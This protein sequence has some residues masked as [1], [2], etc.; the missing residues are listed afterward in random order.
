[1]FRYQPDYA[2]F[3]EPLIYG[4]FRSGLLART[5]FALFVVALVVAGTL[6]MVY[7][8]RVKEVRTLALRET[9]R[10]VEIFAQSLRDQWQNVLNMAELIQDESEQHLISGHEGRLELASDLRDF[11][12]HDVAYRSFTILNPHLREW[13][14]VEWQGEKPVSL[15]E[16]GDNYL[17]HPGIGDK[18]PGLRVDAQQGLLYLFRPLRG[19]DQGIAGYLLIELSM[20]RLIDSAVPPSLLRL[21]A[22]WLFD[23]ALE[24][25]YRAGQPASWATGMR[26]GFLFGD[27]LWARMQREGKGVARLDDGGV[28]AYA[29]ASLP[30]ADGAEGL[31]LFYIAYRD[32]GSMLYAV[33]RELKDYLW[34]ILVLVALLVGG[35]LLLAWRWEHDLRTRF[36]LT[37]EGAR[38]RH[39]AEATGLVPYQLELSEEG[40]RPVYYDVGLQRMLG[41]NPEDYLD[42][43]DRGQLEWWLHRIHPDDQD[44]VRAR[45]AELAQASEAEAYSLRYRV[46]HRDQ[47]RYRWLQDEGQ[48]VVR[49]G[50]V[51][52][53]LGWWRDVDREQH[54]QL[55]QRERERQRRRQ[56][57]AVVACAQLLGRASFQQLL[58]EVCRALARELD[59]ARSG[60][61]MLS[62]DHARLTSLCL[63]HKGGMQ[64]QQT[65]LHAEQ[66]PSYFQAMRNARFID[67][68][69]APH[70]PRT[71]EFADDYLQPLGIS[72]M[73]DAAVRVHGRLWGVI[74]C[75]HLGPMRHWQEHERHFAA[76]MADIVAMAVHERERAQTLAVLKEKHDN[77]DR[78]IHQT[79][80]AIVIVQDGR[81]QLANTLA[82]RLL[83]LR[84]GV[85]PGQGLRQVA[86]AEREHAQRWLAHL[87]L[88]AP[89]AHG[90][91]CERRHF[92]GEDGKF[93]YIEGCRAPMQLH[94]RPA[95]LGIFRDLS[96]QFHDHAMVKLRQDLLQLAIESHELVTF[97][98]R[99]LNMLRQSPLLDDVT[100]MALYMRND[101]DQERATLLACTGDTDEPWP[102]VAHAHQCLCGR[103]MPDAGVHHCHAPHVDEG[104]GLMAVPVGELGILYM[105][106]P[107]YN[108][109]E[110]EDI[111][112]LL[113]A[114]LRQFDLRRH[115]QHLLGMARQTER[116]AHVGGWVLDKESGQFCASPEF[117]RI[118]DLPHE[119]H[120]VSE[121]GLWTGLPRHLRRHV[122]HALSHLVRHD[123]EI[124]LDFPYKA[125]DGARRHL[126]L[127]GR[128]GNA[129]H[130]VGALLDLTEM[131]AL[132]QQLTHQQLHDELTGLGN[133]AKA[134]E[135]LAIRLGQAD[136]KREK[137]AVITI[138]LADF[139]E[140]NHLL[141]H[142]GG[143]DV[144]RKISERLRARLR[145]RDELTRLEGDQFGII[146]LISRDDELPVL[147]DRVREAIGAPIGVDE[148]HVAVD[149]Y[150]GIAVYPDNGD[151]VQDLWDASEAAL[152]VAKTQGPG[153]V[154]Y[155]DVDMQQKFRRRQVLLAALRE[156]VE[157]G[158]F[159]VYLQPIVDARSGLPE[160]A[161]ALIR[162][163]DK[164]L[165]MVSPAEFI[166]LAEERG[167]IVEIGLF[168]LRRVCWE[169][170]RLRKLGRPLSFVALNIAPQ[171]LQRIGFAD[172]VLATLHEHHVPPEAL[173]IEIT[174]RTLLLDEALVQ[175]QLRQLTDA[176]V[177]LALDDFGTGYASLSY[178]G[179]FPFNKLKIDI[180]FIR[181]VT[182]DAQTAAL[183]DNILA[184][185]KSMGLDIVAEGVETRAQYEHLRQRGCAYIQG[186]YF[187]KPMPIRDFECW[188][189]E[190][191]Q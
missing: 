180:S 139:A 27:P 164:T 66:Y 171:Q 105:I 48:L 74:C 136:R 59:V 155:Y 132:Q 128:P 92:H 82:E 131:R 2:G 162:W 30:P 123:G 124:E 24:W 104:L 20:A 116:L 79:P 100:Q 8:Q 170:A 142:K 97:A 88:D 40:W 187:A 56:L 31:P 34:L 49:D 36:L 122:F 107:R 126:R 177:G 190:Q 183:V 52:G 71:R 137:I 77:L 153:A 119:Y 68:D 69:D 186:Y 175:R 53:A 179:R 85:A 6:F 159:E 7:Q 127:F 14:R 10:D 43:T 16:R 39:L 45:F 84:A 1:M 181:E 15:L 189:N 54:A 118:L 103:V 72:S 46:R 191:F 44:A 95:C 89:D 33:H 102:K 65:V 58:Q 134:H 42:D 51:L 174:E 60:V 41:Y 93:L 70:D 121:P 80:E 11:L 161:E 144:L 112:Q 22:V 96:A 5:L 111:A 160:G 32:R 21:D 61:W 75:E 117:W 76:A 83:Q 12:S 185:G 17:G 129:R 115:I 26:E 165:G 120:R 150:L 109:V 152:S 55:A 125:G 154:A 3:D 13:I 9:Q 63:F 99:A 133:R 28:V 86:P 151:S 114:V 157:A 156:A 149:G 50:R 182:R 130:F 135:S 81:V 94:G 168:M 91:Q 57:Q 176:G 35:S 146:A 106:R 145:R 62:E 37:Q 64:K 47:A 38:L 140:V 188:W 169:L 178:L 98:S 184:I 78:L 110:S 141:G 113:L 18:K 167:L 158:S 90:R 147:C 143:D 67:A 163:Q 25:R 138:D 173:H 73:L 172:H 4:G 101:L 29:R 23:P 166:P 108:P 87:L 19:E 148:H